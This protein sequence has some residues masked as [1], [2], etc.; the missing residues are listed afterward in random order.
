MDRKELGVKLAQIRQ[1]K[2]ISAYDLS[3]RLGKATN[4]IHYVETGKI[5]IKIDTLFEICKILQI[6]PRELF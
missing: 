5:N 3:L 6:T 2:N 4:Y 1:D